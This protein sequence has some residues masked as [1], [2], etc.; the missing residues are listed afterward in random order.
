L[1]QV[2]ALSHWVSRAATN[3]RLTRLWRPLKEIEKR[4]Q[5]AK[6]WTYEDRVDEMRGETTSNFH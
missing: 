5:I 1:L 4:E 2:C 6:A 3:P